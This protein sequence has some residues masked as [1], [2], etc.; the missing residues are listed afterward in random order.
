MWPTVIGVDVDYRSWHFSGKPVS[1]FYGQHSRLQIYLGIARGLWKESFSLTGRGWIM[2]ATADIWIVRN[3]SRFY[4]FVFCS[5]IFVWGKCLRLMCLWCRINCMC[6]GCMPPQWNCLS[7]G[8]Y[9]IPTRLARS[10]ACPS[11]RLGIRRV[12][13]SNS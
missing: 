11:D 2:K 12:V 6:E 10:T 9:V 5:Y 3:M 13:P 1:Y 4:C 7:R 8:Y